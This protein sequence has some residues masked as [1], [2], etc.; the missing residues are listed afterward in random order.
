[1]IKLKDI[2]NE[3]TILNLFEQAEQPDGKITKAGMGGVDKAILDWFQANKNKS[4]DALDKAG[5]G[6]GSMYNNMP[7]TATAGG[8][9]TPQGQGL[10]VILANYRK[11]GPNFIP[12]NLKNGEPNTKIVNKKGQF[13]IIAEKVPIKFNGYQWVAVDPGK[14]ANSSWRADYYNPKSFDN[15][16]KQMN[17]AN[18]AAFPSMTQIVNITP[19]V[20][21]ENA[22]SRNDAR[23]LVK[24]ITKN[25]GEAYN[26]VLVYGKVKNQLILWGNYTILK[27]S[28]TPATPDKIT[29]DPIAQEPPLELGGDNFRSNSA[30]LTN[31][32]EI[33]R[34]ISQRLADMNAKGIPVPAGLGTIT[35]QSGTDS[36]PAP[37]YPGNNAGLAQDRADTI[38]QILIS[39]GIPENQ[40]VIDTSGVN[41]VPAG[42]TSWDDKPSNVTRQQ[43]IVSAAPARMVQV[44]FGLA[45]SGG[46][47]TITKGKKAQAGTKTDFQDRSGTQYDKTKVS[48]VTNQQDGFIWRLT[49]N[50]IK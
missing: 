18:Q 2:I 9:S 14:R 33:R 7:L 42:T 4:L 41:G 50:M 27:T 38:Q 16:V 45:Q 8:I 34:R 44:N 17:A 19:T 21:N 30:N 13:D 31:A 26:N 49:V 47:T 35:I 46:G 28:P 39:L 22:L 36:M 11:Y 48:D 23:S 24:I 3:S 25:M 20:V 40:I 12:F 15:G 37:N 5:V 6:P 32:A 1:M 29:K 10:S 43:W